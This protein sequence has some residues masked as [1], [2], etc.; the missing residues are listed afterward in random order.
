MPGITSALAVPAYAG[1]PVTQ[2]FSS[3]SFTVMTGHED[4]S[5]GDGTVNWDAVAH[6]GGTLGILMGVE[7]WPGIAERLLAAGLAPDTSAAAVRWGSRPEHHTTRATLATLGT[8]RWL[9]RR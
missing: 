2:R 4:P 7:H 3:T 6:T 1:I 9:L 5:S 8:I